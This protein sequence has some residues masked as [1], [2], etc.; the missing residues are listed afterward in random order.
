MPTISAALFLLILAGCA[1]AP[2]THLLGLVV[3]N[4]E[5]IELLI[6]EAD[7]SA[8]HCGKEPGSSGDLGSA[9]DLALSPV[10]GANVLVNASVY[11]R[12]V[13]ARLCVEVEGDAAALY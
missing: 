6:L 1:T 3:P 11:T 2:E 12:Q 8:R 9:V 13:G 4:G 10:D 7:V 5:R